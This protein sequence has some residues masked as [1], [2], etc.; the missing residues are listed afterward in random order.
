MDSFDVATVGDNCIDLYLPPAGVSTVGG[1]A[2]NVAV[3]LRRRGHRVAY[4]GAVGNDANGERLLACLDEN[5]VETGHVRVR[6][7]QTAVTEIASDPTGDRVPVSE[8]FGVCR[9]YRP[10][11]AEVERLRSRRHVHLG[12]IDDRGALKRAL[13]ADG[14]SVSQDLTVNA[15]EE[16]RRADG[17]TI[18]FLSAGPSRER[19]QVLMRETLERGASLVVVT[20]GALGSIASDRKISAETGVSPL[21]VVDTTGAGD[22]F[23]A[24][25]LDAHLRVR[26]LR[27]CLEAGRDA[28]A[29]TCSHLGGFPQD[30]VSW[31]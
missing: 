7:G 30:G 31:V 26:P 27:L 4:L 3:H 21:A 6:P 18:A 1:N 19:A 13:V 23:I 14:V 11:P 15:S 24:A 5:G 9:G 2:V 25:F 22:T 17:L 20:C 10:V 28:A 29:E 12:W 8:D 16:H